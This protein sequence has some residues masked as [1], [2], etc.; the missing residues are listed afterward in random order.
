MEIQNAEP[1]TQNPE[2]LNLRKQIMKIYH[3]P[4]GAADQKLSA[5]INRGLDFKKQDYQAVARIIDDVRRNGDNA[6]IDYA[7]RFDAPKLTVGSIKV[8]AREMDAAAKKVDRSFVRALNRAASQIETFHRQ[9]LQQS[10][11]DTR[12]PGTILGQLVNPVDAAGVYVP[13]ATGGKTPLISTVL[14][15]AIPAKIAGVPKLVMVTPSTKA[16][17]ISPHLL[18]AARK[19]GINDIY[20]VGSA[21]AIAALAYGTESIPKVDVIAGPGNIYVTLAKKIVAGTVGIDMIAGPSEVLVIADHTATPAYAAAD[22]L[23]QAEHDVLSS[24]ILVTDSSRVAEAVAA[25]IDKQIS[26]M[27]RQEIARESIRRFGAVLVVD[28]LDAA[29]ELANRIAPEHLEL[30]ID[31]PFKHIGQIRNAGAVFLG[32]HSPEPV[33]DYIAGPNHVL[34][35]AGTARFASALSVDHFIKK[36]SIIHYSKSAFK[37]EAAAVMRL[38]ELEGLDGHVRAVKIRT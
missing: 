32:H 38:A 9:Q 20:K 33:G 14:M 17:G 13:G 16:G 30:Q 2:P 22:L 5:I 24:A 19:V 34:P 15:T 21:W 7:K 27:A 29:I 6:V 25:E 12:R 26:A 35:T 31:E 28:N 37:K 23:S 36:T 11:I 18:V 1:R 3:Y 4:S 10:W 8:T